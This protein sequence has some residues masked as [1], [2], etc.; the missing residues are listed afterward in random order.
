M[1]SIRIIAHAPEEKAQ[2]NARGKLFETITAKVLRHHGYEIDRHSTNVTHAGMEIDIEGKNRITALPLYAECKCYSSD[3]GSEK[4][5]N[6]FGKYMAMWLKN[7]MCQGLFVAL[8]GVNSHAKGFY[9]ENCEAN[10][11]ITVRLLQEPEVLDALTESGLVI[12]GKEVEKRIRPESGTPGDKLLLCSDKGF[13]WLLYLIPIGAGIANKI[14]LF[15]SVGHPIADQATINY[16]A[17]LVPELK[18]FEIDAQPLGPINSFKEEAPDQIVELR[19]SSACFEYQF[20]ASPEF[21]VGRD[22]LLRSVENHISDII[23]NR[24]SSRGILFEA[25]SG[26]GKSSLVLAV[27]HR[28][29]R[30]GHYAVAF[31]CRSASSSQFILKFVEYLIDRFG[32]FNGALSKSPLISG[33][34]GAVRTLLEIGNAVK[35]KD[36]LLCI[37]LDQFENVFYLLDL[38]T[39]I[40][41]LCLKTTDALEN[42]VIGFSWKTDLVGLTREFPYRWR[43]T[44]IDSCRVFRLKQFSEAETNTLLNRLAKELHSALRRDLR[45]FLSEFSQGYPWLLKKLCAHVKSQRQAGI[46]QADIARSLLNVEQLFLEDIEGLSA[47]QEEVLRHI[48][49]LAPVGISDL[50]EEFTPQ[51]VQ[52]LVDRRLIVKVGGKYDIYWDIFRDYL[53]TGKLPIEEVY[54]LRAQVGSIMKAVRILNESGGTIASTDFKTRTGFSDGTFLN[55]AKDLRLLQLANVEYDKLNLTIPL[56]LNDLDIFEH[57]RDHLN[58]CLPRNRCVYNVLKVLRDKGEIKLGDL[59]DK[60]K[61]EFP[62]ISALGRTWETYARVLATWMNISDLAIF[63]QSTSTIF[64]YKIGSQIRDRS[65]IFA[66]KRSGVTVPLIHFAPIV[67]VATRIVTAA[68]KNE[69]CDWDGIPRTTIYKSLSMLEEMKLISR[70]SKTIF[71]P[72]DCYTFAFDKNK[73]ISIAKQAAM[74]WPVFRALINILNENPSTQLSHRSLGKAISNRCLVGWKPETART[75]AKIMIDWARHLGLAPGVH[76]Y[77]YRGRFKH[78]ISAAQFSLFNQAKKK[79]Q[80][81]DN[82]QAGGANS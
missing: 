24:T 74:K 64:E 20:P 23:A 45:F 37:F 13:F 30:S 60:L 5:Q 77:S 22:E 73:R 9:R 2:A 40:A 72:Q 78:R 47:E 43:D 44:I 29:L 16:L 66:P 15:D 1:E 4:L 6:F 58:E 12:S 32:D 3:I 35:K 27:V 71:V 18:E 59:S 55:V 62:Y 25:N 70:K 7:N 33:F 10:T 63:D 46:A 34:D 68:Q 51:I 65:L 48:A 67:R 52:S 75:N 26:W 28:L 38:L 82:K 81:K 14:Q 56:S 39:K 80:E 11:S 36:K 54:L 76:A 17:E 21:F 79:N 42:V 31:D 53:N 50:G 61:D 8:P 41:Q 19:G 49:R 69:A 57:L